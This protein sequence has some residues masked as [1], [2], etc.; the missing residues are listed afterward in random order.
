MIKSE[1]FEKKVKQLQGTSTTL[2]AP[3]P[4]WR[5]GAKSKEDTFLCVVHH[6]VHLYLNNVSVYRYCTYITSLSWIYI[7]YL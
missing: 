5:L 6:L 1:Y 7:H 2:S 4:Q 3:P